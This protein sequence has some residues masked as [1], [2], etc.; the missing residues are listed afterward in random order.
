M[1]MIFI[2]K[3]HEQTDSKLFPTACERA[4]HDMTKHPRKTVHFP[5]SSSQAQVTDMTTCTRRDAQRVE[6]F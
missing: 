5:V 1:I 4:G 6:L 2:R 3:E